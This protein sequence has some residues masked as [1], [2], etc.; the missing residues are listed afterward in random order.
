MT[1]DQEL[2]REGP[3]HEF[4]TDRCVKRLA[5]KVGPEPPR[6]D[7]RIAVPCSA[8]RLADLPRTEEI[9]SATISESSAAIRERVEQARA[10]QQQRFQRTRIKC[11]GDMTARQLRQ[12]CSLD[13]TSRRLLAP[14]IDRLNLS[15]RAYDRILKVA[16]TIADLEAA[17]T[18]SAAH[19]SEAI[20]YR[21]LDKG[22]FT[23]PG[24]KF[25]LRDADHETDSAAWNDAL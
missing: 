24:P 23:S 14:A 21:A 1:V 8:E 20:Q 5:T 18:L 15:A 12:F 2:L 16:R 13:A 22:Y 25:S 17:E 4:R 11:N 9:A 10:L 6:Y 7:E 19:I 3:G